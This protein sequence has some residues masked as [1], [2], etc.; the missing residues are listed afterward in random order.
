MSR[1]N[2]TLQNASHV[3]CT[4][5]RYTSKSQKIHLTHQT[6]LLTVLPLFFANHSY[7]INSIPASSWNVSP[8]SGNIN[9]VLCH[10][11]PPF[12]WS[13]DAVSKNF[14]NSSTHGL[15]PHLLPYSSHRKER[16]DIVV[17]LGRKNW[18]NLAEV[19]QSLSVPYLPVS[20]GH[21]LVD[22]LLCD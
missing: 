2:K 21:I 22:S 13:Q 5:S 9:W 15:P 6:Y 18:A 12:S 16:K 10:W 14:C 4:H 7:T 19:L 11:E 17:D 1:F 20:G 3:W 8:H